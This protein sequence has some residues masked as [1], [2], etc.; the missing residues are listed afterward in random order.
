MWLQ[1]NSDKW[2]AAIFYLLIKPMQIQALS[3]TVSS[4]GIY[5]NTWKNKNIMLF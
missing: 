3:N 4:T 5:M 1:A 2:S